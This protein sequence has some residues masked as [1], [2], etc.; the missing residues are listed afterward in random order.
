[1]A[2]LY[3][4]GCGLAEDASLF[5]L[6]IEERLD[7]P[8]QQVDQIEVQAKGSLFF[9]RQHGLVITEERLID[10]LQDEEDRPSLDTV[11]R[12]RVLLE[13]AYLQVPDKFFPRGW[14]VG[15]PDGSVRV[16]WEKGRR[17]LRVS[18]PSN[19]NVEGYIYSQEGT[20]DRLTEMRPRNLANLIVWLIGE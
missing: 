16:E 13:Q 2:L 4:N 6:D 19:P 18:V 5:Y 7:R 3:T 20:E 17:R 14:V 12:V 11:K 9:E 1:M 8:S 10:L 15:M